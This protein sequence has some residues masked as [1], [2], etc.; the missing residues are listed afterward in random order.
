MSG[1]RGL[2]CLLKGCKSSRRVCWGKSDTGS[3]VIVSQ[4]DFRCMARRVVIGSGE[5][6]NI[7][8]GDDGL[9][10]E[11]RPII[12]GFGVVKL[13]GPLPLTVVCSHDERVCI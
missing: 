11:C 10:A 3:S 8:R 9:E 13:L 4:I 12:S 1:E 5:R 6:P 2:W 7:A